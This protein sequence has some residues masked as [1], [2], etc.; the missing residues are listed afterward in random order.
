MTGTIMTIP[1]F[2]VVLATAAVE[3]APPFD[4]SAFDALL[5]E[6]VDQG[7]VDY[8]AFARSEELRLYLERSS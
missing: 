4:H 6:H 5:R 1:I 7:L 8:D 2:A 3:G